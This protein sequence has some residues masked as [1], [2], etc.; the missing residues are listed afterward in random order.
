MTNPLLIVNADDFGLSRGINEAIADAHESGTL[1]SVSLMANQPASEQA[2]SLARRLPT[3]RVGIHLNLCAGR[4]VLPAREVPS[5][6]RANG[7]FHPPQQLFR[8]LWRFQIAPGEVEKEFRAQVQWARERGIALTHADSH[9]HV[10]LYPAAVRPFV[11]ALKREKI[12]CIRAPRCSVW[13]VRALGAAHEGGLARRLFVQSYRT[14]LQFGPFRDFSMTH[15]RISFRPADRRDPNAIGRCW[16]SALNFLPPGNFE[17]ACHPG[18]MEAGF[19]DSDRIAA[20]RVEEFRWLTSSAFR[21]AVERNRI[22][23]ISYSEL[24]ETSFKKTQPIASAA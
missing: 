23:L 8:K 11:K 21:A 4:P 6:V 17:L 1:T 9:L 10:H 15:S 20:Q 2:V 12:E 3:L 16:I 22:Q 24:R 5:L 14:A 7:D 18:F 13:P 19:S